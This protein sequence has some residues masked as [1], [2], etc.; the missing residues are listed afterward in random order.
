MLQ[1]QVKLY[2]NTMIVS[3]AHHIPEHIHGLTGIG[4]I[5]L[6]LAPLVCVGFEIYIH[7][8]VIHVIVFKEKHST[9]KKANIA[10]GYLFS[11]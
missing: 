5:N 11:I 10:S 8:V 3:H 6:C 2:Y 1:S 9:L 7:Q 4:M